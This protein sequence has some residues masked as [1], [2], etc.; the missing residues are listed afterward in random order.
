VPTIKYLISLKLQTVP[1]FGN[2]ERCNRQLTNKG[3]DL[4][5]L[6]CTELSLI[7]ESILPKNV[8]FIDPV[9][10]FADVIIKAY[11]NTKPN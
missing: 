5:L 6:G 10:V 2:L 8:L 11:H 7:P 4:I 1:K 3:A 9:K